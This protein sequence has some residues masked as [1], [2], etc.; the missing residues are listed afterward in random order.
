MKIVCE[1]RTMPIEPTLIPFKVTRNCVALFTPDDE[2]WLSTIP[3]VEHR[4]ILLRLQ[5]E[6]IANGSI[7]E[8][9]SERADV[10][11]THAL[12]IRIQRIQE[13]NAYNAVKAAIL[14]ATE[15][16]FKRIEVPMIVSHVDSD[17]DHEHQDAVTMLRALTKLLK[18]F[19]NNPLELIIRLTP[20]QEYFTEWLTSDM[21]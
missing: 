11:M 4:N 6:N 3:Y 18:E 1:T 7:K 12:F 20:R 21:K 17:P 10:A 15:K 2:I 14:Y 16:Q 8:T 13:R 9:V 5:T 19:E